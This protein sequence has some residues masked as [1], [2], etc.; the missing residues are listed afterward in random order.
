L[1]SNLNSNPANYF[2]SGKPKKAVTVQLEYDLTE[3]VDSICREVEI[4]RSEFIN[5]AVKKLLLQIKEEAN[6]K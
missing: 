1:T 4:S 3:I 2:L 5:Y 6:K